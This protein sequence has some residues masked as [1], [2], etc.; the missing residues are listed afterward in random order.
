MGAIDYYSE[1]PYVFA[2]SKINLN[3]TLRSIQTGIPLRGM[4]ILGAGGF[5]LTSFQSDFLDYFVPDEDFVYYESQE[6]LVEKVEYYLSH[7]KQRKEIAHNG[8]EKAKKNHSFEKFFENIFQ[9]VFP[10]TYD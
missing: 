1:M 3:I 2:N 10:N 5:L 6:D 4:D 9:I 8:H 7:E